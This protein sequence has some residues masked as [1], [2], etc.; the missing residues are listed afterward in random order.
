M[1]LLLRRFLPVFLGVT[2]VFAVTASESTR[3]DDAIRHFYGGDIPAAIR[4]FTSVVNSEQALAA[5]RDEARASLVTLFR[6]TGRFEDAL[7]LLADDDPQRVVLLQRAGM[8]EAARAAYNALFEAGAHDAE[9]ALAAAKAAQSLGE[10]AQAEDYLRVVFSESPVPAGAYQTLGEL[11]RST[12]R[13]EVAVESFRTARRLEP[14]LTSTLLPEAQALVELGR[15][16]EAR[17]VLQ[18]ARSARPHETDAVALLS[19]VESEAPEL[20]QREELDRVERRA[21]RDAP[22]VRDVP[23]DA[24]RIPRVR[25]GLAEGL[26]ELWLKTG[27][28]WHLAEYPEVT[29]SRGDVIQLTETTSDIVLRVNDVERTRTPVSGHWVTIV[30]DDPRATLLVFDL[31]HSSGQFSAGI[32]DRAYR[33]TLAFGRPAGVAPTGFTMVNE[34]DVES[35]LYSVVPSE[36]PAWWPEAALEAQA[37][38]ARSYTFAASRSRF[39]PRGFDL[40]GSVASAFYRG[41]GGESPRTTAA[42]NATRGQVLRTANGAILSA[43]YSANNAGHTDSAVDV[44][45]FPSPLVGVADPQLG[46][47]PWYRSPAALATWIRSRPPSFSSAAPFS[48]WNAYRWELR[49]DVSDLARRNPGTGTITA[50]IPEGRS[51]AGRVQHVRLI[52][53]AGSRMVSGDAIRSR[54]GGLRSNLF[55]VEPVVDSRG[56]TTHFVFQ[57]AGWGHGV[58]MDQ[59]GAAGMAQAGFSS[60]EILHHYYPQAE[61]SVYY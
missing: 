22:W 56:H 3:L 26:Q 24:E 38:A 48:Y 8:Y 27:A 60:I 47:D 33:G 1:H 36:M 21:T 50:L 11:Q 17:P 5:E 39:L 31:E 52:G 55:L 41:V 18:R 42:V 14:N 59:T 16:S 32:E 9:A 35:Y 6:M 37:I 29:G 40:L 53:S 2:A 10:Y 57:G 54:L 30:Q 25:I 12:G 43:V 49:V 34:L 44:W 45:G 28:D 23:A 61:V 46:E 7:S 20:L 58:G 19:R 13:Y 51:P 15:Y 4:L